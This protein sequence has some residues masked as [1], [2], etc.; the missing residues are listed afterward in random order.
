MDNPYI[1]FIIG[2]G[3]SFVFWLGHEFLLKKWILISAILVS[4]FLAFMA[5]K[6]QGMESLQM[7]GGYAANDLFSPALFL[8]IY[9]LYRYL[10]KLIYKYEPI[11]T[12]YWST[13]WD[14]EHHRK[15]HVGDSLFTVITLVLP[16]LI[17]MFI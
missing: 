2:Y 9:F 17:P 13:S 15:L 5:F 12:S 14:Q 3:V 4:L 16:I 6:Y 10:F 8:I 7:K 11:M 1:Y